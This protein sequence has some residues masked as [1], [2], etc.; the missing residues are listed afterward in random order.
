MAG[1]PLEASPHFLRYLRRSID[2]LLGHVTLLSG[3][4]PLCVHSAVVRS[5]PMMDF[6]DPH[7]DARS[8]KRS[9]PIVYLLSA[10]LGSVLPWLTFYDAQENLLPDVTGFRVTHV[11]AF[12][13]PSSGDANDVLAYISGRC[14]MSCA[15]CYLKGNPGEIKNLNPRISHEEILYRLRLFSRRRVV[16]PRNVVS[17]DEQT[18]HPLFFHALS[19]IR[20]QSE[21][22]I[23]VETNGINLTKE[24]IK[25]LHD[26]RPIYLNVSVNVISTPWRRKLLRDTKPERIRA[27]VRML[28]E[29]NLPFSVSLVPWYT[30]PMEETEKTILWA[31]QE[32][33]N[34]IRLRLP[35]YTRAF[36]NRKL[37]DLPSLWQALLDTTHRLRRRMD[38]PIIVEPNK[39]EQMVHDKKWQ[40]PFVLGAVKGSPAALAGLRYGDYIKAVN[41]APMLWRNQAIPLLFGLYRQKGSARLVIER[42]GQ[43]RTVELSFGPACYPYDARDFRSPYGVFLS[44]DLQPKRFFELK[45]IIRRLQPK[46]PLLISSPLMIQSVKR[47]ISLF[48]LDA[49]FAHM[50]IACIQNRYFGGN[51][52][53]GDLLTAQ[54]VV[55]HIRQMPKNKRPDLI[56]LPSSPFAGNGIDLAGHGYKQIEYRL[57]IPVRLLPG[58][59]ILL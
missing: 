49:F 58:R 24:R 37:Y 5:R 36:S 34:H 50:D 25:A 59:L 46:H 32:Q 1:K 13:H 57:G 28:R 44:D 51:I 8:F 33:A 48:H 19:A 45:R 40:Y 29:H 53:M 23:F 11:D 52:F 10:W 18:T 54:D 55:D 15:F 12:T 43:T 26:C 42:Q 9:S 41:G 14:N 7:L 39:Y 35:G 6:P 16:F 30:L 47:L 17:T 38:T 31:D 20:E 22:V 2:Y 4:E 3:H 27:V 56:I 21:Q